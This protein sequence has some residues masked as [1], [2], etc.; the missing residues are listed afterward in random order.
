MYEDGSIGIKQKLDPTRIS[1]T[2]KDKNNTPLNGVEAAL[3]HLKG[4]A[5][6]KVENW[7]TDGK[8]Y[9]L[10][11]VLEAGETYVIRATSAPDG[12]EAEEYYSFKVS[13]TNEWQYF[14]LALE[15]SDD[16]DD[17]E[18]VVTQSSETVSSETAILPQ[19][20]REAR[21][22]YV[23]FGILL[24]AAGIG[25]IAGKNIFDMRKK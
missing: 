4:G 5:E 13:D 19:T 10:V 3:Y 25:L 15:E 14:E 20:G 16:S 18:I 8:P 11:A 7:T 2:V 9:E 22:I 1:I 23:I 6:E 24:V 21:A 12:Y 17:P